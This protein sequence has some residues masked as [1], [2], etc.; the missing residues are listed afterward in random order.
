MTA[1]GTAGCIGIQPEDEGKFNQM[2]SVIAL[3]EGD[4]LPVTV[5]YPASP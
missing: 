2:M 3:M 5:R 1:D 4:S